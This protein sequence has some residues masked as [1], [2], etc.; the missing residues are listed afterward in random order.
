MKNILLL[1]SALLFIACNNDSET[2]V[3]IGSYTSVE[4]PGIYVY[5]FNE[6]TGKLT[7]KQEISN[8][9]NPSYLAL[10]DNNKYLYSVSE[11]SEEPQVNKYKVNGDSLE[12]LNFTPNHGADPCYIAVSKNNNYVVTA[13]YTGGSLSFISNTL[14]ETKVWDFNDSVSKSHIHC[15]VFSP[16][17]KY[18]FVTDLGKDRIYRFNVHSNSIDYNDS[19]YFDLEKGSGPRHLVFHPS[20]KYVYVINELSGKVTGFNYF[21]GILSP[22]QY[23]ASDSTSGTNNKGSGDIHISPD[24]KFLYSSNRLVADG[25][26]IFSIDNESG[27]LTKIAYQDTGAHPR[28]FAISSDGRFLLVASR[29]NNEIGVFERNMENGLLKSTGMKE[30]I[31]KPVCIIFQKK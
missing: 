13:N 6:K 20:N 31:S 16:D 12:Y 30:Q 21:D 19:V 1:I 27:L 18:L 9:E 3:Y 14:Q 17:N 11:R 24:G 15:T 23:V 7:R 10:S 25:I 2:L 28:N 4:N 29:D 26:S 5:S 8:V 22:F